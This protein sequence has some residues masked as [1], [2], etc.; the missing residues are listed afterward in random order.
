MRLDELVDLGGLTA[1]HPLR[2]ARLWSKDITLIKP[3][4]IEAFIK[5]MALVGHGPAARRCM[6]EAL[7]SLRVCSNTHNTGAEPAIMGYRHR[8]GISLSEQEL[9]DILSGMSRVRLEAV[10]FAA[11]QGLPLDDIPLLKWEH[12][13]RMPLTDTASFILEKQP[14]HLHTDLVFWEYVGE[15]LSPLFSIRR[16]FEVLTDNKISWEEFVSLYKGRAPEMDINPDLLREAMLT[17]IE[18]KGDNGHV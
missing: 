11:E 6:S 12:V 13:K 10:L 15:K 17:Q 5:R 3:I 9:K 18:S 14:R 1:D 2:R 8:G 16:Q 7:S 4:E